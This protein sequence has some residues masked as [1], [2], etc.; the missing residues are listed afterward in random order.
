MDTAEE[1]VTYTRV[2]VAKVHLCMRSTNPTGTVDLSWSA[3]ERGEDHEQPAQGGG[4][5]RVRGEIPGLGLV[6]HPRQQ[7]GG[8]R[9]R[10][11]G[12]ELSRER[13]DSEGSGKAKTKGTRAS[14]VVEGRE[15]GE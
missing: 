8:G 10:G 12:S 1:R 14:L 6:R 7:V 15:E 13:G 4:P 5:I 9:V 2:T 11:R 3:T